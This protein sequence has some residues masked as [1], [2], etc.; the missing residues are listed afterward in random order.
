MAADG[1]LSCQGRDPY[2]YSLMRPRVACDNEFPSLDYSRTATM[3]Q[4]KFVCWP[5]IGLE[6]NDAVLPRY[7][8]LRRA[9][10]GQRDS[11][12]D[13]SAAGGLLT[14]QRSR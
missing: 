7:A 1:G 11:R 8:P 2:A 13:G 14:G 9:A 5:G 6:V 10:V 3:C 12:G 4:P